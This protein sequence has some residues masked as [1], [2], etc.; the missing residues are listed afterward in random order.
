MLKVE[1]P[2]GTTRA[3]SEELVDAELEKFSVWFT[4]TVDPTPLTSPEKAAIKTW[5]YF[6]LYVEHV[7]VGSVPVPQAT[8]AP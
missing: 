2:E 5:V 8:Q 4:A 7:E 6:K 3:Q 1:V